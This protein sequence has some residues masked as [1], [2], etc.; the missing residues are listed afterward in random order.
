M[1]IRLKGD[2]LWRVFL[3]G[4]EVTLDLMD[5]GWERWVMEGLK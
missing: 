3:D 5:E 1:R 4:R 2:T